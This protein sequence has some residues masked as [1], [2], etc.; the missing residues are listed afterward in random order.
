MAVEKI[1][2]LIGKIGNKLEEENMIEESIILFTSDHG[3]ID[4]GHGGKTLL[5]VQIP[6]IIFGKGIQPKGQLNQ[7]IVTYDTG[8]TIAFLLG[9]DTPESWRGKAIKTVVDRN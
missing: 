6:W 7:T 1:D 5:E 8:A 4:K 9:L 2:S 3:G